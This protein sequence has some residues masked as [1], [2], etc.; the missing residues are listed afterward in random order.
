MIAFAAA[1]N[2]FRRGVGLEEYTDNQSKCKSLIDPSVLQMCVGDL[3]ALICVLLWFAFM[4]WF[5]YSG[6]TYCIALKKKLDHSKS[7]FPTFI[8][9]RSGME[10]FVLPTKSSFSFSGE[11]ADSSD[12]WLRVT[13]RL[14]DSLLISN[15]LYTPST[16]P[17]PAYSLKRISQPHDI[18]PNYSFPPRTL[19]RS[20]SLTATTKSEVGNKSLSGLGFGNTI[21]IHSPSTIVPATFGLKVPAPVHSQGRHKASLDRP[22]VPPMFSITSPSESSIA[23]SVAS[24]SAALDDNSKGRSLTPPTLSSTWFQDAKKW[25]G[26]GKEGAIP[27]S[28]V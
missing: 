27:D 17:P 4:F 15:G 11:K 23:S 24:V 20:S 3:I 28:I 16:V 19:S 25:K 2:A 22:I 26:K 7:F 1:P 12:P 14:G 18:D 6:Y 5:W 10:S 9:R 21:S 8:T 13:A